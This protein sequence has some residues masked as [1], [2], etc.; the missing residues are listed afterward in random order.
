MENPIKMDD[1]G[2]PFFGTIHIDWW[3]RYTLRKWV[4]PQHIIAPTL[5]FF[6]AIFIILHFGVEQL[7]HH[8]SGPRVIS[9]IPHCYRS[10]FPWGTTIGELTIPMP[11]MIL[12]GKWTS[13]H[14]KDTLNLKRWKKTSERA[15]QTSM[16]FGLQNV[17]SFSRVCQNHNMIPM[18]KNPM[19]STAHF[20][21]PAKDH[22]WGLRP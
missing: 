19:R 18:N 14:P 7:P 2:F 20:W 6:P 17:V 4:T 12:H 3:H 22:H 15:I 8:E 21:S 5:Y 16:T 10:S 9:S 1:R 13:K 11:L